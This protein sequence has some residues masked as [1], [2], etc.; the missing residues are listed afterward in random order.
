MSRLENGAPSLT[1]RRVAA[2]RLWFDRAAAD[3]GDPA[4]DRLRAAG[5]RTGVVSLFLLEGIAVYLEPGVLEALLGQFRDVA[6]PGSRIAA[7]L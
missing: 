7:A 6:A 1:V 5:L 3:Y 2:H 4:A